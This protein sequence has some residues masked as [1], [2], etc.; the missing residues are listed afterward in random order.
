MTI[1][2]IDQAA[3]RPRR[4]LSF[5]VGGATP[6]LASVKVTGDMPVD[7]DLR[8]GDQLH[9]TVTTLDGE[10]VASRDGFV[11][12]ISFVDKLDKFGDV[13]S[14]ERAHKVTLL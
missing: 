7:R 12:A 1:S 5:D 11:S 9:I 3:R 4:Q 6:D 13:E 2:D 10:V 8:K 14:T